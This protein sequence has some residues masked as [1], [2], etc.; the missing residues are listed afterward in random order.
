MGTVADKDRVFQEDRC[1]GPGSPADVV[2]FRKI[3]HGLFVIQRVASVR[4]SIILWLS[5]VCF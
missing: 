3:E 2:L 4:L 1:P 5:L